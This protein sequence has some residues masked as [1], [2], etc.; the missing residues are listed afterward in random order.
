MTEV[1]LVLQVHQFP[2]DPAVLNC[3]PTTRMDKGMNNLVSLAAGL[4]GCRKEN[5]YCVAKLQLRIKGGRA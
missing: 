3:Y 1:P 4:V 2:L 5:T